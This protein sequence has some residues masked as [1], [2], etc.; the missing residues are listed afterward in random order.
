MPL[1]KFGQNL[2]YVSTKRFVFNAFYNKWHLL[3]HI[4]YL[5]E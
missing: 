3:L 1:Y 5:L 4:R 2:K